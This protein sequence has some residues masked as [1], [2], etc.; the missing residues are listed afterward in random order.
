MQT[1]TMCFFRLWQVPPKTFAV[2]ASFIEDTTVLI[3]VSIPTRLSTTL[4]T[5]FPSLP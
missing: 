5:R 2:Q 4:V 3:G 1:E